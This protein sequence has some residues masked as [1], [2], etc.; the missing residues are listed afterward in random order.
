M[1]D[2]TDPRSHAMECRR[3]R[4]IVFLYTDNEMGQELLVA[5]REHLELC[6][7]CLQ[8]VQAAQRLL[9]LLRARCARRAAPEG[10]RLRI[11]RRLTG[12]F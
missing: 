12:G 4:Q 3:V 11:V 1:I 10:L 5:F 6:P 2:D 8:E 7:R 9:A